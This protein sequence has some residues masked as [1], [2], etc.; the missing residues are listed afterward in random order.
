[1]VKE[2]LQLNDFITESIKPERLLNA[3]LTGSDFN[4]WSQ[5]IT[6]TTDLIG[7]HLRDFRNVVGTNKVRKISPHLHQLLYLINLSNSYRTSAV[8]KEHPDPARIRAFYRFT[9][10]RIEGLLA[11]FR[12][13]KLFAEL[14]VSDFAAGEVKIELKVFLRKLT[15]SLLEKPGDNGLVKLV[16]DVLM[17][18]IRKK[19]LTWSEVNRLQ[20]TF[21]FL[22][23]AEIGDEA[24]LQAVL[25]DVD[26]N[27]PEFF[28]Y[29]VHN[30]RSSL[31]EF[32]DLRNQ[33]EYLVREKHRIREICL[34]S[35]HGKRLK[36]NSIAADLLGYLGEQQEFVEE[37]LGLQRAALQDEALTKSRERFPVGFSVPLLGLFIRL[38]IERG[39]LPKDNIGQLFA[40]FAAHF[41]TANALFISADNLQK[42]STDVEFSTAQKMKAQLIGMLNW[43]NSNFNLSN[44]S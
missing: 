1:M 41:Y 10:E 26:F 23:Q 16:A 36:L 44:Y 24:D 37:L 25:I 33:V 30:W 13:H 11:L 22:Q 8:W 27:F 42:K 7:C 6:R 14:P 2:L 17:R 21:Y 31:V 43:L 32:S 40:F 12:N 20:N 18:R 3:E 29:C 35:L 38:Q 15:G 39:I 19:G 5:F 34:G 4:R 9:S 28:L